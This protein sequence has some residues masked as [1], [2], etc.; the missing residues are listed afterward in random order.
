MHIK[1]E[2]MKRDPLFKLKETISN[3]I[4]LSMRKQGYVKKSHTYELLCCSYE[5]FT[6][7]LGPKPEG[8]IELDHICPITQGKTEWEVTKLQHYTNFQWLTA[9]ENGPS[10]KWNHWTPKGGEL[11]KELL[12]RE[13]IY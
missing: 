13:W 12:N 2:R 4:R 8:D 1:K 9:E 6:I 7:H 10:C 11:C 5:E 3:C